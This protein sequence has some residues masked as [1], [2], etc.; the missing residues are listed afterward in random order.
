MS[1]AN[2]IP[3]KASPVTDAVTMES[4]SEE[5]LAQIITVALESTCTDE[6]LDSLTE[7]TQAVT[8]GVGGF[9]PVLER[10]IVKLDKTAKKQREYKLAVLHVAKEM[11]LKEYKQWCTIR[12]MD[13]LLMRKMEKRCATK[14]KAYMREAAK[15]AKESKKGPFKKVAD[16]L[17]R[18]QRNTQIAMSG[19]TQI[20]AQLKSQTSAIAAKLQNN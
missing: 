5:A 6:E 9:E 17:T 2:F 19:D 16:R 20:P 11:G 13:T 7:G 10:S 15:K 3:G 1:L 8:E 4:M 14:A 18:S 12:K